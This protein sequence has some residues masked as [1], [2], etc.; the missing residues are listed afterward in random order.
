[1]SITSSSN[2]KFGALFV[3][4]SVY[5]STHFTLLTSAAAQA[6]IRDFSAN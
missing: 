6:T 3:I 1:M 4:L 2:A 5:K